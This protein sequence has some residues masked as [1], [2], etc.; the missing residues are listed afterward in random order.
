[1][2]ISDWSSDVCSSDLVSG[3]LG[4]DGDQR[5]CA[6]A[7]RAEAGLAAGMA[8]PRPVPDRIG[9]TPERPAPGLQ[10][11]NLLDR[12]LAPRTIPLGHGL[13]DPEPVEPAAGI[14]P[15]ADQEIGG[16]SCRE[17]VCPYVKI[18]VVAGSLK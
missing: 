6:E 4:V 3:P 11:P 13:A 17:R 14:E 8:P 1:M 2:R 16:A 18:P 5:Q 7:G 12:T 10:H 15:P 9:P